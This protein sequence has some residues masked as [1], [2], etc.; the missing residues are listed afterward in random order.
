ME[1]ARADRAPAGA[2]RTEEQ[3]QGD[4]VGSAP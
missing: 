2:A 3:V 4:T 1:L